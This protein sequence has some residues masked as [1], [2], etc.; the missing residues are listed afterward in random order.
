M[1]FGAACPSDHAPQKATVLANVTRW[2]FVSWNDAIALVEFVSDDFFRDKMAK[3]GSVSAP[4]VA[5]R[6]HCGAAGVREKRTEDGRKRE[7]AQRTED[8]SSEH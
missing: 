1:A 6:R 2:D 5:K 8:G 4:G 7:A 3:K